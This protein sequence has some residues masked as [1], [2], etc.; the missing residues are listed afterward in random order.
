MNN[1]ITNYCFT[2]SIENN[3]YYYLFYDEPTYNEFETLIKENPLLDIDKAQKTIEELNTKK[4][5]QIIKLNPDI[6]T[7][8]VYE[9]KEEYFKK[10]SLVKNLLN[11]DKNKDI[12]IKKI[13]NPDINKYLIIKNH[14]ITNKTCE[15]KYNISSFFNF[16]DEKEKNNITI[17]INNKIHVKYCFITHELYHYCYMNDNFNIIILNNI[18]EDKIECYGL[19]NEKENYKNM[20]IT[21]LLNSDIILSNSAFYSKKITIDNKTKYSLHIGIDDADLLNKTKHNFQNIEYDIMLENE[22]CIDVIK[23]KSTKIKILK[24]IYGKGETDHYILKDCTCAFELLYCNTKFNYQDSYNKIKN[25]H[26][27]NYCKKSNQLFKNFY[28]SSMNILLLKKP[29]LYNLIESNGCIFEIILNVFFMKIIEK[30]KLVCDDETKFYYLLTHIIKRLPTHND[31]ILIKNFN[32]DYVKLNDMHV[33]FDTGNS[34]NS[35]IGTNIVNTLNLKKNKTFK[36]HCVGIAKTSCSYDEYVTIEF[37]FDTTEPYNINKVYKINA[38][39]DNN[40]NN[41]NQI[42]LGQ[43]SNALKQFFDDNYS[44]TFQSKKIQN[45]L[46]NTNLNSTKYKVFKT[47]IEYIF[48]HNISEILKNTNDML[49]NL[50]TYM[51]EFLVY[52]RNTL[53][54]TYTE[55]NVIYNNFIA[56]LKE[57]DEHAETYINHSAYIN[58]GSQNYITII[59]NFKTYV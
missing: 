49:I 35:L 19:N 47:N 15:Y 25:T 3:T 10:M 9:E 54:Y 42:L 27:N 36:M 37:K 28:N 51:S 1:E 46:Q 44:I 33:I 43:S 8:L 41:K 30:I 24:Y 4:N 11:P 13:L 53:D 40:P 18:K 17:I 23:F 38:Y 21:L 34:A 59:N 14:K 12:I 52:S 6:F 48:T 22:K 32:D 31:N 39:V 29:N 2:I 57:F 20:T 50:N 55:T 26:L 58:I 5:V 56:L 16:F 45:D 7:I